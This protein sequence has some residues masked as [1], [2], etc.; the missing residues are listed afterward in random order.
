[1]ST[2]ED[3]HKKEKDELCQV[4]ECVEEK[5]CDNGVVDEIQIELATCDV[6][7]NS[8]EKLG[9]SKSEPNS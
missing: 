4:K 8:K 5:G 7:A 6:I 3:K 1:M 2:A 9:D